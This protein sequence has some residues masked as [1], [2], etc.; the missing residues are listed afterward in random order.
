M[1]EHENVSEATVPCI[2]LLATSVALKA[3]LESPACTIPGFDIPDA[4]WMPFAD[5]VEAEEEKANAQAQRPEGYADASCSAFCQQCGTV[6][7]TTAGVMDSH[8]DGAGWECKGSGKIGEP[9][10]NHDRLCD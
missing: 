2:S 8:I 6:V 3:Y 10:D 7:P 5:A 4:I 1:S 9:N